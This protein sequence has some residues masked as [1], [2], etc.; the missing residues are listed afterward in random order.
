MSGP[1]EPVDLDSLLFQTINGERRIGEPNE[2]ER[3]L[4]AVPA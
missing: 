2:R 1:I 4:E 3:Q